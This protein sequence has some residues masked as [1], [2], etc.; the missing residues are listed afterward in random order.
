MFGL[1]IINLKIV[2]IATIV[3]PVCIFVFLFNHEICN[4]GGGKDCLYTRAR[5][6]ISLVVR[7]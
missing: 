7:T 1:M 5:A 3:T 6:K 2:L 4:G